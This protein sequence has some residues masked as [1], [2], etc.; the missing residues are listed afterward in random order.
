M[1]SSD[2][3]LGL[4]HRALNAGSRGVVFVLDN[5]FEV[6]DLLHKTLRGAGLSAFALPIALPALLGRSSGRRT[7]EQLHPQMSE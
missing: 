1:N 5:E 4:R 7:F 3:R 6:R 2:S